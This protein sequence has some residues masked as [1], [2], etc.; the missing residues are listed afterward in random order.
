[1]SVTTTV[2]SRVGASQRWWTLTRGDVDTTIANVGFNLAQ[3]VIPVFL[4]LPV[5]IP[6]A[7]SVTRLL[8]G[9]ALGFLAGSLG[10]VRLA[11]NLARREGRQNVP[12]HVY[13]N[14]VPP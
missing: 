11:A 8:P 6:M 13:A 1:M 7:F 5:G 14:N 10:L 2:P 12:A 9:Y 4:L 3:L